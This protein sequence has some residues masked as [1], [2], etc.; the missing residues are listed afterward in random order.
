MCKTEN[1]FSAPLLQ[2]LNKFKKYIYGRCWLLSTS[3]AVVLGNYVTG[4]RNQTSRPSRFECFGSVFID[5][6]NASGIIFPVASV[7]PTR[8]IYGYIAWP[9][10]ICS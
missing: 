6:G 7:I 2:E 5:A 3:C 1:F 4:G 10:W 9:S 8:H